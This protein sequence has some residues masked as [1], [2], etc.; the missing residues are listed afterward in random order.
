M[1]SHFHSSHSEGG[2]TSTV[3]IVSKMKTLI[4]LALL[5]LVVCQDDAPASGPNADAEA[6]ADAWYGYYGYRP[7]GYAGYYRP[8]GYWGYYGKRS[9]DD[10]TAASGPIPDADAWYGYYGHGY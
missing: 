9:A 10:E 2:L 3:E 1:G 4:A 7:W 5:G 6:D 8:Y